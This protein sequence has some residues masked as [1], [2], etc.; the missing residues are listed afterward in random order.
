LSSEESK[1]SSICK[2]FA[3]PA[4]PSPFYEQVG[5]GDL[6]GSERK[7]ECERKRTK[8]N[9]QNKVCDRENKQKRKSK[10]GSEQI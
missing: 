1:L 7:S 9:K 3:H 6:L 8:T 10:M 2:E 4:A 5:G